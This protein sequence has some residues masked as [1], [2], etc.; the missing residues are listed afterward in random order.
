[1]NTQYPTKKYSKWTNTREYIIVHHTASALDTPDTNVVRYLATSTA[2]VSC[3]YVVGKDWE[4]YVL[5]SDDKITRHAGKSVWNG[6]A[7]INKYSIGIEVISDWYTFTQEQKNSTKLLI[8]ELIGKYNLPATSVL[9]HADIAPN[10]KRDIGEKFYEPMTWIQ[11]QD[12]LKQ[13]NNELE[14]AKQ[15]IKWNGDLR[16]ATNNQWLRKQLEDTNDM[17]RLHYWL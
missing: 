16:N 10:R 17:I 6:K 2:Q 7:D 15:S 11:Y 14:K 12:S 1:M 4:I 3:H 8:Q 5:A 9:R 13:S